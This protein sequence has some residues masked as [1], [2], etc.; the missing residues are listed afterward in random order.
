MASSVVMAAPVHADPSAS[1]SGAA[2]RLTLEHFGLQLSRGDAF[3]QG[4]AVCLVLDEPGETPTDVATQ[5]IGMHPTW[6]RIDA[7]HFV[8]AAEE[9][10]CPDKLPRRAQHPVCSADKTS[11]AS[12]ETVDLR[13][14]NRQPRSEAAPRDYDIAY[15]DA[16]YEV[17]R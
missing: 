11:A 14:D 6:N 12:F 3:A 15:P 9:R 10:Y 13:D 1:D 17:L 16:P 5:V 4:V 2:Y 7:Q 8:G